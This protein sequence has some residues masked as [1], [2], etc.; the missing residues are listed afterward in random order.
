[1][2]MHI[3]QLAKERNRVLK[4]S[5]DYCFGAAF[6]SQN[7]TVINDENSLQFRYLDQGWDINSK[8]NHCTIKN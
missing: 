8:K 1:M 3:A 2:V 7:S 4:P 6:Q 5:K